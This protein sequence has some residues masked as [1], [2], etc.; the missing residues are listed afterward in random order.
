MAEVGWWGSFKGEG[1]RGCHTCPL[2][3]K[4]LIVH[5]C[6]HAPRESDVLDH[7]DDGTGTRNPSITNRVL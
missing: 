1:Y 3:P 5:Q 2:P 4:I 6:F 7:A